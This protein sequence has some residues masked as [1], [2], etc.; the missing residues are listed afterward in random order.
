MIRKLL[1]L[2]VFGLFSIGVMGQ[3][4]PI[5]VV[6]AAEPNNEVALRFKTAI[7]NNIELSERFSLWTGAP[8]DLPKNG[9]LIEMHSIQ[10]DLKN[11]D[12]TGAA[13]LIEALQPSPT[14]RGYFKNR[15]LEMWSIGKDDS[16]SETALNFLVSM[17]RELAKHP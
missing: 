14:E 16:V 2:L 1:L 7:E 10:L 13:V 17:R 15:Y 4:I 3:A 9:I 5:R 8:F 6:M 11:G 12:R